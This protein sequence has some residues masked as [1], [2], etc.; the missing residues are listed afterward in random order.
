MTKD[1]KTPSLAEPLTLPCGVTVRNRFYK[2]A[3]NEALAGRDCAPTEAHVRLYRAWA[4]GGA[5]VLVT[6]NVMVDRTQ[7]GEPGNVAVEDERDL[8]MLRRWA[9]AGTGNGAHCWMQINHP[10]RQSPITINPHP[11][12]PST[13][14]V[15]GDYGRFFAEPT[16][17]TCEQIRDI[18]RRFANTARIAKKAGFTG[19]EI[20][21]AHGYLINQFLS[22]L[23]NRRTDEYGGDIE[24]RARFLFEVFDAVREAVGPDFP[25]AVKLNSSD[26]PIVVKVNARDGVPGGFS[27]EESIWVMKQLERRGVDLIDISGGTYAKPVIQTNGGA[28]EDRRRGVY[29]TD[30]A[31]RIKGELT[32]PVALTGGFRN[33]RDMERALDEGITQMIGIARPLALVPDLPNRIIRDRW[34]GSVELP[35]VTTGIKPLDK[36]FGGILV[37]SWFELQMRRIAR[38]LRPDPRIGGMRALLFA[39]GQHGPA[40]LAPRRRKGRQ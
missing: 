12:A 32:V 8:N 19:V 11:L 7:L 31:R 37:I 22:P 10:G 29:F 27:E 26:V 6:G 21:A 34:D 16:E 33:A 1:T 20:H 23:D 15:D 4:Q 14:K 2:S 17:L 38:G 9:A 39:F 35:R 30:F 13:G 5:G 28:A 25:V 24:H 40:A 3:M 18:V 36:A